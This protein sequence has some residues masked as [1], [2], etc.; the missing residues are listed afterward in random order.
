MGAKWMR[1]NENDIVKLVF[2]DVINEKFEL[3]INNKLLSSDDIKS[4][5]FRRGNILSEILEYN[6]KDIK[7]FINFEQSVIEEFLW[8]ILLKKVYIGNK[9]NSIPNKL[10]VLNIAKNLGFNVPNTFV[11]SKK[12]QLRYLLNSSVQFVTKALSDPIVLNS[13]LYWI[14]MHTKT[15]HLNYLNKIPENFFYSLIQNQVN[16]KVEVRIAFFNS[17]FYSVGMFLDT[18]PL[19]GIDIRKE[20]SNFRFDCFKLP[21]EIKNKIKLLMKKLRLNFGLIDIAKYLYYA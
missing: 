2:L 1:I 11:V 20:I 16:K 15:L 5:W 13:D 7:K 12:S 3:Q 10:S 9:F 4:V 21:K 19:Q 17:K 14:P 18:H 6:N 8:Y